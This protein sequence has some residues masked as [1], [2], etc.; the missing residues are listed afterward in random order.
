MKKKAKLASSDI[1]TANTLNV[2]RCLTEKKMA[3]MASLAAECN[4]TIVTLTKILQDL[5]ARGY[6]NAETIQS[7]EVGRH[8]SSYTLNAHAGYFICFDISFKHQMVAD[9]TDLCENV[10]AHFEISVTD[11]RYS[12]AFYSLSGKVN[13]FLGDRPVAGIGISSAGVY[14]ANSR[15]FTTLLV[16]WY[17]QVDFIDFFSGQY[18]T[19]NIIIGQDVSFAALCAADQY[20]QNKNESLYLL[21]IGDG[22]GGAFVKGNKLHCGVDGIAGDI[23]QTLYPI[24][25]Q[26]INLEQWVQDYRSGGSSQPPDANS[27]LN[28]IVAAAYN[29]LWLLNPDYLII[30][31]LDQAFERETVS[32][33]Q[34]FL[35]GNLPNPLSFATRIVANEGQNTAR[36]GLQKQLLYRFFEQICED[37]AQQE[38]K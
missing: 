36:L 23:G 2:L 7:S 11:A 9:I 22:V 14:R 12:E 15:S 24:G 34:T 35:Q 4:V 10:C 6:V 26:L 21:Y 37:A 5:C 17:D 31:A 32:Q 33:I 16:D 30:S 38:K 19:E 25:G 18:A 1:R 27:I 28:P 3:T 29:V 8:G 13:D 20:I